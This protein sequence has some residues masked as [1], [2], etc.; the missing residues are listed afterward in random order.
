MRR[1]RLGFLSEADMRLVLGN[2]RRLVLPPGSIV[3]DVHYS[4]AAGGYELRLANPAWPALKDDERTPAIVLHLEAADP[5][6]GPDEH[7]AQCMRT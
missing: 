2:R 7:L 6:G 3:D 4:W 5:E 1:F